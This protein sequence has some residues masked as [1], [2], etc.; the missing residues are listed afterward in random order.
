MLC[1]FYCCSV[2]DCDFRLVF[3][4][5]EFAVDEDVEDADGT[6]ALAKRIAKENSVVRYS[7]Q[8][9]GSTRHSGA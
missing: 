9:I 6:F 7:A 5:Q 3:M 8:A 2:S 1:F 4:A